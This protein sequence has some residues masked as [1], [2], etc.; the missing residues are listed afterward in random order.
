MIEAKVAAFAIILAGCCFI[1]NAYAISPEYHR[2]LTIAAIREYRA[3]LEELAAQDTLAEGTTAIADFT[4][5]ED[6]SP[7][8][9][10]ALNWHF[11]DA[12]RGTEHEMGLAVTGARKSMHH[13]Y[14]EHEARLID[15][16]KKNHQDGIYEYTGRLLHLI[17]DVTVPAH[18]APIYHYKFF[19][20]DNSDNFDEM[21]EWGTSTFTKPEDLCQV[22][23]VDISDLKERL[24]SILTRTALE[25]RGRIREEI[26]L[27]EGHR[28]AGK[29]WQEFWVVRDPVDDSAYVGT[30]Y[31][32]APYGNEGREGFRKLCESP[33]SGR[34]ACLHFLKQ[35]FDRAV[36]STVKTL[37]LVNSVNIENRK[38]NNGE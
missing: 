8:I 3:C 4:K 28:L 16:L 24:D 18:V 29:T 34:R 22:D 36:T 30:Y 13:I 35:S 26:F 32:F 12:Y 21:P 17:Q 7:L 38:A 19:W 25:T 31:G 10:R 9:K 33:G 37:L 15:A 11:Y 5:I 2:T 20:F 14:A 27:D 23:E 6:E 1:G